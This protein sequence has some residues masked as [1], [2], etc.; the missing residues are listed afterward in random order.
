M[1][2][3]GQKNKINRV[4]GDHTVHVFSPTDM[5]G[6]ISPNIMF[7]NDDI[8]TSILSKIFRNTDGCG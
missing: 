6:E 7:G 8:H 5:I 3:I 1:N 4:T 2:T